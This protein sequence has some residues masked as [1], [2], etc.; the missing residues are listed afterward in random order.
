MLRSDRVCF[1][2][3]L[4]ITVAVGCGGGGDTVGTGGS[5]PE[6]TSTSSS[7]TASSSSSSAASSSSG[8]LTCMGESTVLAGRKLYFGE[9]TS[10]QW[11]KFGFNLDGL[12]STAS[13]KDVCKPNAGAFGS[14]PYPDGEE[15]IDNSFGKNLLPEIVSL[16]P[17]WETG[18]NNGINDGFFNVLLKL[19]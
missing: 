19:E 18:I 2:F 9:G 16:Y 11:K 12:V 13:S 6:G 7:S 5:R 8:G 1:A 3:A 10:G 14:T 17:E 4:V 15:G